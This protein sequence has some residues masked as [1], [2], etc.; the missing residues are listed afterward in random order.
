MC[1]DDRRYI[2]GFKTEDWSYETDFLGI[3]KTTAFTKRAIIRHS[4]SP[5]SADPEGGGGKGVR[6]PLENHK[7]YGF[8]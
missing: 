6:T 7:L 5:A 2:V 4:K 8:L 1:E 3:I